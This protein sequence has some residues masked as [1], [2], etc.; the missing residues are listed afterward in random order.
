MKILDGTIAT[1][2]L[3][4][5]AVT[6]AKLPAGAT[7][8]TYLRGDGTWATASAPAFVVSAMQTGNY[9]ALPSEDLIQYN[10][11]APCNLTLPVTGIA[12]GKIYYISNKGTADVTLIPT[13]ATTGVAFVAAGLG[14]AFMWTGSEYVTITGY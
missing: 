3:A 6:I 5:N 4:D 14:G 13:P 9:T 1:A 11:S 10:P 8:S 7:A 2:K 12:A